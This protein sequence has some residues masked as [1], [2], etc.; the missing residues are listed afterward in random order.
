MRQLCCVRVVAHDVQQ[1]LF[2]FL[3]FACCNFE[4]RKN[5]LSFRLFSVFPYFEGLGRSKTPCVYGALE[6]VGSSLFKP[7]LIVP[8]TIGIVSVLLSFFPSF[9]LRLFLEVCYAYVDE[10]LGGLTTG[11]LVLKN[12]EHFNSCMDDSFGGW[13]WACVLSACSSLSCFI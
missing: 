6:I 9:R 4:K 8:V 1:S 11:I 7:V 13:R 12:F 2:R 10:P 5:T 3:R